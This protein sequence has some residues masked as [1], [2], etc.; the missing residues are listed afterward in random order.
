MS[1]IIT[2][3]TIALLGVITAGSYLHF[4][5]LAPRPGKALVHAHSHAQHR[6]VLRRP[7]G[8]HHPRRGRRTRRTGDGKRTGG[9]P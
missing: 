1:T 3:M 4:R 8:R 7:T 6:P 2:L 5:P 9:P